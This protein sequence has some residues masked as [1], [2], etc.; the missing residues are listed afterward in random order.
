VVDQGN[1]ANGS[2]A[3]YVFSRTGSA[4]K[5][6]AYLKGS[7]SEGNDALGFSIAISADG[8]TIVGGAAD[9]SCL[10]GGINPQGCNTDKPED[11]SGGSSG[12][13]YI[14]VRNDGAWVEQAFL[15]ASTPELQDWFAA[16]LAV[17]ADGNT[18]LVAAPME[19]SRARGINGDQ[20][21]NSA[22]ESG[23]AYLFRRT[24]TTWAQLAYIKAEN[25]EEFDE[26]G[27]TVAVSGDGRTLFTGARMESG[28]VPGI[29]G[30]QSD[31]SMPQSGAVYVWEVSQ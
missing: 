27:T 1:G 16:N 25:A 21:D 14:W 18:L 6:D 7:R 23:A 15:K 10:V 19:D 30:N 17:S 20:Q 26:F 28:G 29:N 22:V 31:N 9:E 2:G 13:A 24:G 5:Q 11:A 8:N 4:W 12:A 3:L